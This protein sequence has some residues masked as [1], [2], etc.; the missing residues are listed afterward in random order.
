MS[1]SDAYG[2]QTREGIDSPPL[3]AAEVREDDKVL[4][5]RLLATMMLQL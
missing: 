3:L 1:D 5:T 2:K 4:V